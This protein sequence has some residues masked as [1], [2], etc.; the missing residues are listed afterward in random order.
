MKKFIII[1]ICL[2]VIGIVAAVLYSKPAVPAVVSVA[3]PS[4][5]PTA[6]PEI[7]LSP[8][9]SIS[10][11]AVVAYDVSGSKIIAGKN[12][13]ERLMPASTTKMMTAMI[14]ME[15]YDPEEIVTISRA[16]E[17]IGHA[18]DIVPGERL[19][20]IDLIK[21]MLVNSGN[22]AAVSLA[23]HH[24]GG[25]QT[26][27]N[28]MNRKAVALGLKDTHFS[29]VS[30][31]EAGDHYGS[32]YDLSLI[33]N[34]LMKNPTLKGFVGAKEDVIYTTDKQIVHKLKNLN[35]LLWTVPGV[36]GVKTGWTEVAGDCLA[37]YVTRNGHDIIT[38][39]LKS[40]D[41]FADS[42]I[43]IEWVFKTYEW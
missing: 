31:V 17:A 27:V 7:V 14:A 13:H 40:K 16:A 15:E 22:D 30:G 28:L 11:E 23:D 41:R 43:L 32:A 21:A 8:P 26:F 18:I 33:A 36:I 1:S 9:A 10:A 20:V 2:V 38:V 5:T 24:P 42:T 34:E 25:Y 37:T 39:V 19:L 35:E 12:E 4:A 3:A 29:N 6:I